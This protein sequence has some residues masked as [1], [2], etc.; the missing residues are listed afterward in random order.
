VEKASGCITR[1]ARDSVA[2]FRRSLVEVI[3]ARTKRLVRFRQGGRI[4][5]QGGEVRLWPR[6]DYGPGL[7]T[8]GA[9]W[10]RSGLL[11]LNSITK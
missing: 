6:S 2:F 8:G 3:P 4:I 5:F 10:P 7:G 11:M 9:E 1:R